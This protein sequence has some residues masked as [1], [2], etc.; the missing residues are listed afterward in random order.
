MAI[1]RRERRKQER[2]KVKTIGKFINL[3]KQQSS[4]EAEFAK[5]FTD[6]GL[7]PYGAHS[8]QF[9]HALITHKIK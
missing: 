4:V 5:T 6:F 7:D 1:S 8:A 2:E 3:T 9:Q